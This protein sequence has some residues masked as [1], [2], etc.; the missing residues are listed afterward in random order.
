MTDRVGN[1]CNAGSNFTS[2]SH[3][4]LASTRKN[5]NDIRALRLRVPVGLLGTPGTARYSLRIVPT[6][7]KRMVDCGRILCH[8]DCS[9]PYCSLAVQDRTKATKQK[10]GRS[11]VTHA[12]WLMERCHRGG[13]LD[14]QKGDIRHVDNEA[15][16][17][18]NRNKTSTHSHGNNLS[19]ECARNARKRHNC[20][21][22]GDSF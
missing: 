14:R 3:C 22:E 5:D 20:D 6:D 16:P 12:Q 21:R 17:N 9:D 2:H 1:M 18:D 4:A 13:R 7:E 11:R 15:T 10:V 8:T 19:H